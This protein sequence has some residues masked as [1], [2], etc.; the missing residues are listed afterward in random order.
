[1]LALAEGFHVGGLYVLGL[2]ALGVALIVAVGVLSHQH[3]RAFSAAVCYVALG[4]LGA[5]GL[6]VL[7]VEP[8][9]PIRDSAL[10]ERLTELALVVAVFAAGLT[11]EREVRRRS[12]TSILVL[13]LVVMPLTIVVI[14]VF[15]YFLMGLSVGAAVLLGAVLA[16]TD[17]VLAGDVGLGPPGDEPQGEPRLSLHTEAGINDGLASPFVLIGL[18]VADRGGT[19]W[20]GEWLWADVLYA[21]GV[22]AILGTAMG[23][24]AA[25][26][27]TRAR[28][29]GLVATELDAMAALAVVLTVYGLSEL[30]GAYGLLALFAA[31]FAFRRYEF[32]HE[33]HRGIHHGAH[34]AGTVLELLVLL[35]LGSMLTLTGLS[36][37]GVAGWLLAPLIILLVRPVLV[38]ATSDA[39][40]A[41]FSE[42]LFLAFFG[43]R[44]V[45]AL[46]YAAVVVRSGVLS[47]AETGL[48]VW[49]TVVCVVVSVVVHGISATPLTR[50]LL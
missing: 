5:V 42:R 15:G 26:V 43:V 3:E 44:G 25:W 22:A 1:M 32:E 36:T 2:L 23:A 41:S 28:A 8:V 31:G 17:P 11:V 38:M 49:T 27:L 37:P 30:L 48:V 46:F 9:D 7:D 20:I 12:V 16:P 6:S 35:L 18:F 21:V 39:S 19:G 40:L 33:I 14:A 4:A 50:R 45:A 10:L 13:L 29:R 34:S 24:G 47:G